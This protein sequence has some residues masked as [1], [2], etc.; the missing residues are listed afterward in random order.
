VN[1]LYHHR[2]QGRGGEGVHIRGIIN[3][4]RALG[5]KVIVLSPPGIDPFSDGTAKEDKKS[6]VSIVWRLMS[7]YIPQIVFELF[8][9]GY[10]FWVYGKFKRIIKKEKI[11]LIY[12]RYA[13]FCW[14]GVSSAKRYNIPIILEVNEVSGIKRT[15]SQVLLGLAKSIE[16][17]IFKCADA[18]TTVS[19]FLKGRIEGQGIDDKNIHLIP[20]AVNI[21]EFKLD[22]G[23]ENIKNRFNLNE[24]LVIGFVGMFCRWDNLEFLM[25]AF[26]DLVKEKKNYKLVL[27]GDG[28]ERRKLEQKARDY[29]IESNVIFTGLVS[30][31][32]VSNFI[33]A[34]DIC[35]I[36]DSNP[37]GS[38]IILFEY[39]AMAK[40]TVA[41]R[42]KPMEDVIDDGC[43]GVLFEPKDKHSFLRALRTLI[44]NPDKR[45][46]IG[47]MARK[48]VL[49][50]HTWLNNAGK[51][52][53]I[54]RKVLAEI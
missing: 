3:G 10:N 17:K 9:I 21:E 26:L 24:H 37:F 33:N 7:G 48:K 29:G 19:S 38:P 35:V 15:R 47:V 28:M 20:N 27:I 41:P 23:K 8:E 45:Q 42:L 36:P 31:N 40:P 39:M 5:N 16:R 25:E 18:I 2:T 13:F 1:I 30:R 49:E 34:T 50:K 22:A 43:D 44:E 54:Y 32:E 53:D 52:M 12:E 6:K 46:A 14:A 11:D 4:L 51:V